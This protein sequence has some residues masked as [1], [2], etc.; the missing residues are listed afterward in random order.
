M[1]A[2][3][4]GAATTEAF[5]RYAGWYDAFNEGK[6][7]AAEVDYLLRRIERFA[8]PP[9]RW[10]DVGCGTGR[11]LAHLQTRGLSVEG[12]DASA[13]MIA[14]AR[15]AHPQVPFHVGTAQDFRLDPGRDV[16]SLLF[17]VMSY[18]LT[19]DSLR[20][21]LSTVAAHLDPEGVLVF[22]FWH[23]EAVRRDP[24]RRRVRETRIEGRPLFRIS[25][26]RDRTGD[27]STAVHFEFRWDSPDGPLAHRET[28]V[29]RAHTQEEL[30]GLLRATGF[31][32]LACEGWM[33]GEPL[34]PGNWYGLL[35]A[36][37]EKPAPASGTVRFPRHVL[38]ALA[39]EA[40]EKRRGAVAEK[41]RRRETRPS[42]PMR[43]HLVCYEDLDAWILGKM[44]RRLH[45]ELRGMGQ[46]ATLGRTPDPGADVNHHI[47]Y[48][49]YLDRT[50]TVET[51]MITHIDEPRELAKVQRQ[52]VD[53]G[54]EMGICMSFEAVHRLEHFGVPR[55]KLCFITP[56]H[57]GVMT[58][59]RTLVGITTRLYPDGRK[60]EHLLPEL[61]ADLSP[62]DFRF[63]IMGSGW[64][65]IVAGLR[66]RGFEVDYFDGFDPTVYRALIP[67]LDYFLYLGQDEGSLGF[68][69]ALAAGVPTIVTPQ[70]FHLDVPGGITHPF[71]D[72]ADLRR[73]FADIV[74][75]KRK[76]AEAASSL[77]WSAYARRHLLVWEYLLTRK[78]GHEPAPALR[79]ELDELGVAP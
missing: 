28:H 77:T 57:D 55:Q 29:L 31:A 16:I 26:P 60:R 33:T 38:D 62:D 76:R 19:D 24:P 49:D 17:H 50:A 72:L 37:L 30:E 46:E 42:P 51:V 54:V 53:L 56:A 40:M 18:Q 34:G 75:P 39:A 41:T 7:Y 61:A 69:D 6:D 65:E 66:G 12:V 21:A 5:G 15:R 11:H 48:W 27:G 36:R 59:R 2:P 32:V 58:P 45:D 14:R 20:R 68:L 10:L 4:A 73:I 67:S 64:E 3:D 71:H 1:T 35:L 70:G 23:A 44:A 63:A 9:R 25:D 22:D 78:S 43:I 47:I 8:S 74:G 52:L 79:D 13:A